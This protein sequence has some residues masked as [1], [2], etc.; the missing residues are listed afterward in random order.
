L[1]EARKKYDTGN[2]PGLFRRRSSPG[3]A[4]A[5]GSLYLMERIRPLHLSAPVTVGMEIDDNLELHMRLC[6][7]R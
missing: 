2:T 3:A 6:P 7:G 5:S 4:G 1:K